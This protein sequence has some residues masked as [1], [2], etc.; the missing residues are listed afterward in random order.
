MNIPNA[1]S[2]QATSAFNYK[3]FKEK[4]KVQLETKIEQ[5]IIDSIA[6]G[7]S[8]ATIWNCDYLANFRTDCY[9]EVVNEIRRE[10]EEKGYTVII[11]VGGQMFSLK[12][13]WR[14]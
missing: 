10:L 5:E 8:S 14:K 6:A 9:L 3:L 12:I 2:A 13:I 4:F 7:Y 11:D 1:K